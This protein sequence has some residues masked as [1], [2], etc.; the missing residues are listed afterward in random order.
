[1]AKIISFLVVSENILLDTG[2]TNTN[3]SPN[4]TPMYTD[5]LSRH[6]RSMSKFYMADDSI[7][8]FKFMRPAILAADCGMT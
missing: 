3:G 2:H 8:I 7:L 5:V 4:E 6:F 1:M